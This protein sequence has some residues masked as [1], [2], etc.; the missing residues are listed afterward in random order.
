GLCDR[1]RAKDA[2]GS[3]WCERC[4][5]RDKLSEKI[6]TV[7]HRLVRQTH[8]FCPPLDVVRRTVASVSVITKRSESYGQE[9]CS[10][11]VTAVVPLDEVHTVRKIVLVDVA[12]K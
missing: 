10:V 8:P 2:R 6:R 7:S 9:R 1:R 3:A 4:A 5:P 11:R 12:V